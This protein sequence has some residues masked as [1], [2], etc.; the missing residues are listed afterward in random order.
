MRKSALILMLVAS[1]LC[2]ADM[3]TADFTINNGASS[4]S[5]GQVTFTLNGD[6]TI[7]GSL[8]S[9]DGAIVGLGFNSDGHKISSNFLPDQYQ[10]ATNWA[11]DYGL[12]QSGFSCTLPCNDTSV[13]WTIGMAGEFSSVFQAL[14]GTTSTHDFFMSVTDHNNQWAADAASTIV[15]TPEPSSLIR[16]VGLL[17]ALA[18]AVRVTGR[19]LDG[20]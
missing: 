19:N 1:G 9:L 10:E 11:D 12:Q 7:T 15:P 2:R 13:T 16:L 17:V 5:G 6:G 18:F 14:G 20:V 3:L 4:P 8:V